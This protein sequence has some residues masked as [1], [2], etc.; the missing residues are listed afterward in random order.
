MVLL[1]LLLNGPTPCYFRPS[2]LPSALW[3]PMQCDSW[4][5]VD[6]HSE[7]MTNPG[8]SASVDYGVHV[9]LLGDVEKT[10]V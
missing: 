6:V 4:D 10:I 1:E 8:P 5:S 7:N 2:F 3:G 9:I